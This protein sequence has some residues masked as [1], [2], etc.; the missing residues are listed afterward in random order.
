M[1]TVAIVD[2]QP[3]RRSGM[4]RLIQRDPTLSLD[5][6]VGYVDELA[7]FSTRCDVV[8]VDFPR[9]DG[10]SASLIARLAAMTRPVVISDWDESPSLLGAI[11]AGAY[12]CL[13]RH[14]DEASVATAL[15]VV[16][17]GGFYLCDELRRRLHIELTG[18]SRDES[19]RLAP[20]EVETLRWIAGG[21]TQAQIATRMGLSQATINTYAKRIRAKLNATN[22]ADLTRMAIQMG[23]VDDGVAALPAA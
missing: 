19:A 11:R 21:F 3:V 23:Y 2:D 5:A 14:T 20:R 13:S 10:T 22:K 15:R 6:S 7:G 9:T 4:E 1:C 12:A 16:A 8:V 18:A 17:G